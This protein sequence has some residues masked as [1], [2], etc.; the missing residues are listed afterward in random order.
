MTKPKSERTPKQLSQERKLAATIDGRAAMKELADRAAF[1]EKNTLRLREL[2]LAKEV[3]E[4]LA[5]TEA[6]PPALAK[7]RRAARV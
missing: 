7:S 3:Q 1:V 2:R 4:A 6:P 5:A